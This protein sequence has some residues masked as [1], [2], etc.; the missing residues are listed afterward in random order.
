MNAIVTST[1]HTVLFTRTA[2][3]HT[4]SIAQRQ[5]A[6]GAATSSEGGC[7]GPNT[8]PALGALAKP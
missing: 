5:A 3:T 8:N 1:L 2:E 7:E 4:M 6:A